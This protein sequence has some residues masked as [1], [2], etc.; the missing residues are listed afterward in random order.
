MHCMEARPALERSRGPSSKL[1]RAL[2]LKKERRRGS[3]RASAVRLK[4]FLVI[5]RE[6]SGEKSSC[7][8][9]EVT[10]EKCVLQWS[11]ARADP[12]DGERHSIEAWGVRRLSSSRKHLRMRLAQAWG[13]WVR[14]RATPSCQDL[15]NLRRVVR[16]RRWK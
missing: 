1:W 12:T 2:R 10:E 6:K 5:D 11:Q 13:S 8:P 15:H 7:P 16:T 4:N 14:K 9:D 3:C